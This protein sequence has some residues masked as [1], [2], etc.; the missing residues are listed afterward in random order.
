ME[1]VFRQNIQNG[2]SNLLCLHVLKRWKPQPR[3]KSEEKEKEKFGRGGPKDFFEYGKREE[4]QCQNQAWK[5]YERL[6]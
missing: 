6:M 2:R 3:N 1:K 5:K 4:G